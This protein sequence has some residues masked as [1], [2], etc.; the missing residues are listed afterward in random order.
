MVGRNL[1]AHSGI[2]AFEVLAPTRKELDL[3]D[4]GAVGAF[5]GANP[6]DLVIHAAGKVGGIQANIRE[7]VAFLQENLHMGMNL[8]L[9]AREAGITRL[10]NLGS[11]CMYPCGSSEPLSEDQVLQG[12][13]EPTNEGYAL[14]KSVCA[15][16]CQY[17][18][19]EDPRF[20]FKTLIPCNLYGCHD[21]FDPARSHLIPSAIHKLHQAKVAGQRE[22]SIW[23]DGSARRE[24]MFAGDFADALVRGVHHFDSLP[25]MMNIGME[26]D[27]TVNEY[28]EVIAKVVGFSGRFTHDLSR[29]V[30]MARKKVSD[31]LQQAWGWRPRTDLRS[32][33]EQTYAYYLQ[34]HP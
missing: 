32:G 17:V 31:R 28:Y 4:P 27:H 5:L 6:V 12:M 15:R 1:L 9:G 18:T 29:P 3:L 30:G 34:E 33:I 23:G 2:A 13:L 26:A 16:L 14:A 21:A 22:V 25:G 24:F 19:R 20:Q 7:P 10:L 8:I 11:S